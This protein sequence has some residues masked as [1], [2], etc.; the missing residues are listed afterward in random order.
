MREFIA[1][2]CICCTSQDIARSPAVLMPFVAYRVFGHKPLE[3]LP[4]WGLRDLRPGMAYTLCN[5]LQCQNCGVLFLDYR[6]NDA[7]MAALYSG[8]RDELYNLERDYYEHGYIATTAKVFNER[9][10]YIA[11]VEL[12]LARYL[13]KHPN[14]LDWGGGTGINTPFLNRG[15]ITHIHDV[16]LAPL[17]P[18]AIAADSVQ[19]GKQHY[20]LVVCSQVLEHIPFPYDFIKALLPI[21]D[22]DTLLYLEVPYELLMY[23]NIGHCD[24]APQKRHWHEHVNFFSEQSLNNLL[25]RLNLRIIDRHILEITIGGRKG[26]IHGIIV[27]K[28]ARSLKKSINE[29]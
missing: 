16:S 2:H 5:S 4:E 8:Y 24:L 17:V 1:S 14:T 20:D 22:S 9:A 10:A 28:A 19:V 12:W 18:G 13:P 21:M 7:Q 23:N 11:E 25:A 26:I 15:G 6:F 3:I 29:K 27:N